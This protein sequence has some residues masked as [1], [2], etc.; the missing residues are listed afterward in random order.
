[1]KSCGASCAIRGVSACVPVLFH[2]QE[3][4]KSLS[5]DEQQLVP[6]S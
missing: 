5:H 1:L 3:R 2:P 4:L 6:A